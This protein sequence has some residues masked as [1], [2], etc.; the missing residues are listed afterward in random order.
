MTLRELRVF[1]WRECLRFRAHEQRHR[2]QH[3]PLW[4]INEHQKKADFHLSCVQCLNQLFPN[5]GDTAENDD[6]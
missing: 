2:N 1:H 3:S 5:L 6:N 4:V